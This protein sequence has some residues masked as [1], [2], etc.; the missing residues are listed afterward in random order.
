M[1][2]KIIFYCI[3]ITLLCVLY[4]AGYSQDK[5]MK[6][7]IRGGINL[8]NINQD[9]ETIPIDVDDIPLQISFD[10]S[11]YTTFDFGGFFEYWFSNTIGIQVNGL[12][13][14][15]GVKAKAGFNTSFD[16]LGFIADVDG[17]IE[18]TVK[19]TYISFPVLAKI[20][21]SEGNAVR[22]YLIV[23]PEV[24]FLNAAEVSLEMD[25]KIEIATIGYSETESFDEEEDIKDQLESTE[26]ALNIGGGIEFPLGSAKGFLDA[27]YALGLSKI[28]KA[29]EEEAEDIFGDKDV[30]N[31]VIYIN[32]GIIF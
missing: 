22:P 10:K 32:V 25:V 4:N 24:G 31:N 2:K 6:F 28:N 26:F 30:K 11:N 13:N 3:C 12:Y 9:F 21:F 15:K 29:I 20:A 23:G 14:M 5:P 17:D 27:R 1:Y 19:L 18:G 8:A 7:G 16:T